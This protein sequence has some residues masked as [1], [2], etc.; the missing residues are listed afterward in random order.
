[1]AAVPAWVRPAVGG[2]YDTLSQAL[3]GQLA[4][5]VTLA[6]C[7]MKLAATVFSY[8]SGACGI[9]A[10]ALFIKSRALSAYVIGNSTD[11]I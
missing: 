7:L 11:K 6:L 2:G 10:P 1:M 9:F 8:S 5:Q 3:S 4:V